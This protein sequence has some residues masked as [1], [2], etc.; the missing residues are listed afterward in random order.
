MILKGVNMG[1]TL[2]TT[3]LNNPDVSYETYMEWFEQISEMNANTVKVFTIMN[4]DFIRHF[5]I[6]TKKQKARYILFRNMV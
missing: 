3:N 1:L 2:A 4:P 5:T 6:T